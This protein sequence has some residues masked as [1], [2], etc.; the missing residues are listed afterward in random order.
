MSAKTYCLVGLVLC[1]VLSVI[2]LVET[3]ILISASGGAVVEGN[4]IAALW[5]AHY[6]WGGLTLFKAGSVIIFTG[7]VAGLIRYRPRVGAWVV[8]FATVTLLLVTSYSLQLL[9]ELHLELEEDVA[10]PLNIQPPPDG[11]EP[12]SATNLGRDLPE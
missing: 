11:G 3:W 5:L 2:D 12:S 1:A 8:T 7:S 10:G 9:T 4:P 6:G